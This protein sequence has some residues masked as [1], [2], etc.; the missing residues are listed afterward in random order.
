MPN[1]QNIEPYSNMVHVM[2]RHGGPEMFIE[3]L[4]EKGYQVG[5]QSGK[6]DE[7][8]T[9]FWKIPLAVVSGIVICKVYDLTQNKWK[10]YQEEMTRKQIKSSDNKPEITE[11]SQEENALKQRQIQKKLVMPMDAPKS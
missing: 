2:A 1:Y 7:R 6:Q 11:Q 9:E 4:L 8:S 10:A 3:Y 5:F